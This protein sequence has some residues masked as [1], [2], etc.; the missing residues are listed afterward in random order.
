MDDSTCINK[1]TL[2]LDALSNLTGRFCE[3]QDFEELI[4]LLLMTLCGQFSVAHAFALLFKPSSQSLNETFFATGDFKGN[5]RLRSLSDRPADWS[6]LV[7]D[8]K[9]C[10]AEELEDSPCARSLSRVLHGAGVILVSPLVHHDDFFGVIGLGERITGTPYS[11]EDMDLLNTVTNTVTP[12]VANSYLFSDIANLKAWYL[13]ILDSVKQGVFVF[14]RDFRLKK[15]NAAGIDMLGAVRAGRV[16]PEHLDGASI[17]EVFPDA[18]FAGWAERFR[19]MLAAGQKVINTTAVA[20]IG[21]SLRVFN[22]DLI[23]S[24]EGAGSD[25][26]LI[27]T[28]DDVTV[29]KHR[30]QRLFDLQITADRGKMASTIAHELNNFLTLL[31]GGVELLGL[32]LEDDDK[33]RARQTMERLQKQVSNL[34]RFSRGLTDFSSIGSDK[35]TQNLNSLIEGVLSFISVQKRFRG[36][37]IIP[38]LSEGLPDI[39]MDK[40][41]I[42][43]VLLNLLNNAAD[44]IGESGRSDGRIILRTRTDK[45]GIGLQVSDNGAGLRP[46]IEERLFC[47]SITTKQSGHG[48][49]L[50]TCARIIRAHGGN[51]QVRS[52]PGEGTTFT[53]R[54]PANK[55]A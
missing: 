38:V 47:E 24:E 7:R 33:P 12:L 3:K 9:T 37:K 45:G 50:V 10:R 11:S 14:D 28:L 16:T 2:A 32:A 26:S 1:Q 18:T 55:E 20:S 43:Q 41:Q 30:E 49:G 36:L 4:D 8:R 54:F 53:I 35:R 34:E 15:V 19:G 46:G 40:D 42:T 29:Q 31:M 6:C 52:Q 22:V 23:E 48:F 21:G 44:A 17:S 27:M 39:R 13:E 5:A 51:I 25:S